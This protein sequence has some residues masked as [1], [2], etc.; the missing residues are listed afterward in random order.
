[1]RH[2]CCSVYMKGLF[3]RP[4]LQ[5]ENRINGG[6]STHTYAIALKVRRQDR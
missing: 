6:T 3:Y 5:L 2:L 4:S 1:M